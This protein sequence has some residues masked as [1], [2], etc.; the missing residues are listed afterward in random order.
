MGA[1]SEMIVEIYRIFKEKTGVFS[2]REAEI[3]AAA[4]EQKDNLATRNDVSAV[5]DDLRNVEKELKKDIADLRLDTTKSIHA[6][7][8][9]LTAQISRLDKRSM[10]FMAVILAAIFITNPR[11]LD[12]VGKLW[13]AL[14]K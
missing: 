2:D 10:I 13:G 9:K 1:Q 7:D 5:K 6:L 12:F 14:L 8:T 3:I 4:F 11:I